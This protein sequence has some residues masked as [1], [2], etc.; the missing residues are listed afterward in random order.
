VRALAGSPSQAKALIEEVLERK[1]ADC[2]SDFVISALA[3]CAKASDVQLADALYERLGATQANILNA[4][5]HFYADNGELTRACDIFESNRAGDLQSRS[6]KIDSRVER[7]LLNAALRCGRTS[8]AKELLESSP[9][10]IAKHITMIRNCSSDGNLQSAK[11]VFESLKNSGVELNSIIYNTVLDA[12][13]NCQDLKAAEEWMQQTKEAGMADVVS[14]N[15]LIKAYLQR[16]KLD[17]ARRLMEDMKQAGLQPNRV[18][19]NELI[20]ASVAVGG[21]RGEIWAVVKEMKDAGISANQVTC[22]ILLKSL[23]ARSPE[24][25]VK[26]TMEMIDSMEEA[27]DE[28]LLSSVV[29]ACV[30]IGKP[31]LLSQKLKEL[32]D[33]ERVTVTGSHTFGS[34]IK[35]YGHAG[36]LEGAWRCWKD[37]RSRHVKPTSITLGCMIEAVVSNGDCEGAYELLH[38]MSEDDQCKAIINSVVYCSVLKGFARERKL[39]RVWA[40]Y[41]EMKLKQ[42]ELTIVTFN[43]IL[44]ACARAGR[45]EHLTKIMDDMKSKSI[46]PNIVT[47]STM[48]K[49]HCQSGDVHAGFA[50]MEQMKRESNLKP[51]E[52]MYNSLLDGC[53]QQNLLDNGLRVLSDMQAEGVQPSNFTLSVLVKLLN[54]ARKVDQAFSMVEEISKKYRFQPN[55]H[56]YTNLMQACVSNRQLPR[57][58]DTL[59][60]MLCQRVAPEG[61]AYTILVKASMSQGQYKQAV[62]LLRGALGL[63]DA[64]AIV[65]EPLATCRNLDQSLVCDTLDSLVDAGFRQDLAVPLFSDIVKFCKHKVRVDSGTQRRVMGEGGERKVGGGMGANR[66]TW[67]SRK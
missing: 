35:A 61:R 7:S 36:D 26:L 33:D 57:A 56:V 3:F 65:Q 40:V 38:Q 18:T 31:D 32:Q 25:D 12:C 1:G 48:I 22:S 39:E 50:L 11:D 15:T 29:E 4:F 62:G 17:K 6:M 20:N 47:Y 16:N 13:V 34:L 52:I 2:S 10:D 30:R 49:G 43:T 51:D 27:M 63:A 64:L 21:C 5:V 54:R 60:A 37:M 46:S 53:A 44:D 14:F 55:V 9:S 67:R 28:V 8:L 23:N 42:V 59:K 66:G 45:M 58:L 19:Y 41:D 24:A